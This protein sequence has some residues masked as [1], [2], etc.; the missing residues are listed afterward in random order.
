M[1]L[2][3]QVLK[4]LTYLLPP[5]SVST[6]WFLRNI[7]NDVKHRNSQGYNLNIHSPENPKL[8]R[9]IILCRQ[10]DYRAT[11]STD[12]HFLLIYLKILFINSADIIGCLNYVL[13]KT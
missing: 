7:L 10:T 9:I 13:R 2:S 3:T 1:A 12:L 6:F 11:L 4:F 5:P 8:H